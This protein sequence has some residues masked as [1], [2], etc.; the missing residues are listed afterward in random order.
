MP[1][2]NHFYKSQM[3]IQ[4][5]APHDSHICVTFF[6]SERSSES[7]RGTTFTNHNYSIYIFIFVDIS[8]CNLHKN[9][10]IWKI[11]LYINFVYSVTSFLW[12]RPPPPNFN[13]T[14]QNKQG[15]AYLYD[16]KVTHWTI[17]VFLIFSH[18]L[19]V[20]D[21]T[22]IPCGDAMVDMWP[23]FLNTVN[24]VFIKDDFPDPMLPITMRLIALHGSGGAS[25]MIFSKSLSFVL[26]FSDSCLMKKIYIITLNNHRIHLLISIVISNQNH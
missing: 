10:F 22:L 2:L 11:C 9:D 13:N 6:H 23:L 19:L 26:N 3:P 21:G 12:W 4:C 20:V 5:R 24:N 15:L 14:Q 17:I 1:E 16:S 18:T 7:L 25:P 8:T